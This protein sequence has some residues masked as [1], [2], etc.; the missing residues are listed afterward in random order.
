[1]EVWTTDTPCASTAAAILHFAP[2][3]IGSTGSGG[4]APARAL[5]ISPS[6]SNPRVRAIATTSPVGATSCVVVVPIKPAYTEFRLSFVRLLEP[7]TRMSPNVETTTNPSATTSVTSTVN[8]M[9]VFVL[10]KGAAIPS[11]SWSIAVTNRMEVPTNVPVTRLYDRIARGSA[12]PSIKM[13]VGRRLS[14]VKTQSNA[15]VVLVVA[16]A[17][18]DVVVVVGGAVVPVVGVVDAGSS[19]PVPPLVH[20]AARSRV[21]ISA[22]R[23][24][25]IGTR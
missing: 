1:M 10:A 20:A 17:V 3:P 5:A 8:A 6:S 25:V 18:V 4:A 19:S 7:R 13:T 24:R 16:G 14:G 21:P 22:V 15:R 11:I 9:S 2:T 23:A 12:P